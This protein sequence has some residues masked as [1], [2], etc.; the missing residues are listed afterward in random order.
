MDLLDLFQ[1]RKETFS[2]YP[3]SGHIGSDV[4]DR[5]ESRAA[6]YDQRSFDPWL[7]HYDVISF[8]PLDCKAF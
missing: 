2:G 7:S 4:G 5:D 6:F 1:K 3:G 8:S